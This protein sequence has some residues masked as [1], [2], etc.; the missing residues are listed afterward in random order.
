[1]SEP[2]YN[3]DALQETTDSKKNIWVIVAVVL[4]LLCCCCVLLFSG[5]VWLWY[6]GDALLGLTA[7]LLPLLIG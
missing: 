5:A 3:V 6:N 1:M 7:N 2:L 4:V